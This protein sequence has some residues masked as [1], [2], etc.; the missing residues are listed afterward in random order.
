MSDEEYDNRPRRR[1]NI[2]EQR[3]RRSR[4]EEL[5]DDLDALPEPDIRPRGYGRGGPSYLPSGGGCAGATIYATIGAVVMLLILL[6]FVNRAFGS[7][8]GLFST[9]PDF[10]AIVNTPT[11]QVITGA[12]VVR[13]IQDLSRLE[14]ASYTIETVIDIRQGSNI[15]II[16]DFLAGDELL[17]IAHGNVVAGVDLGALQESDVSVSPDGSTITLRLPPAQIFSANLND[18]RTRV[19]SRD[20]GLFA[21]ENKDLETQARQLAVNQILSGACEDGIMQ[22]ATEEAQQSLTQ[23][24]GLL[25]F[26]QIEVI[27]GPSSP[28]VAPGGPAVPGTPIPTP[29]PAGP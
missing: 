26:E 20:R 15:P 14:T 22:R 1:E 27:A 10:A 9:P 29:S 6:F 8:G 2:M 21:P 12:A 25:E 24:L 17:L 19:Y 13:R 23:F 16:G 7:I 18:D 28:C 5:E 11:P 3:L 4:D